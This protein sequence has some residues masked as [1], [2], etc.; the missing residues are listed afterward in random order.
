MNYKEK[1][2]DPR[3]QKKRLE[4]LNRDEFTCV[5]CGDDESTLHVHHLSYN[6]DPWET[7]RNQL[8][9]LCEACHEYRTES[10]RLIAKAIKAISTHH[11]GQLEVIMN[12][13]KKDILPIYERDLISTR[14]L[15]E[16]C[17]ENM[18]NCRR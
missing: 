13:Y 1:L 9:T 2:K 11:L 4:I 15:L 12:G 17:I 5:C 7:E 3:W 14:E 8:E 10:D 18:Y 16:L 6:G